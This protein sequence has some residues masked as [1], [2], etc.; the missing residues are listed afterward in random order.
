MVEP[1]DNVANDVVAMQECDPAETHKYGIVATG[2]AVRS[3][4]EI[5]RI[6]ERPSRLGSLEPLPQ[7]PL[8][9]SA[10]DIRDP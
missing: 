9:P 4:F 7:R 3:G 10:G 2:A 1:Y 8:H 5:T 6:V